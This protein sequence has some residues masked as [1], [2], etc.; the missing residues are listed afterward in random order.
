MTDENGQKRNT[1]TETTSE[2]AGD[3]F[4]E[5]TIAADDY[6]HGTQT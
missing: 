6:V 5:V 1:D 4:L 3:E 2:D